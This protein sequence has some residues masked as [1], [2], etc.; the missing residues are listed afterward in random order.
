MEGDC[1]SVWRKAS[2]C[3]IEQ[4]PA[5]LPASVAAPPPTNP[6]NAHLKLLL[7]AARLLRPSVR[8]AG[9]PRSGPST[10][11]RWSASNSPC[12]CVDIHKC[13]DRA[14]RVG[15]TWGQMSISLL[16][17]VIKPKDLSRGH[18]PA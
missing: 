12:K 4:E 18:P 17:L 16:G 10:Y 13:V 9:R 3:T 15:P 6:H 14:M 1:V 2:D 11:C 8:L 5:C 7:R